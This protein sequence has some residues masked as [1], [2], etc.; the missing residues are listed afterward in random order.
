M[1][2]WIP[3][4]AGLA[5]AGSFSHAALDTVL[6]RVLRDGRVDYGA[7]ARD[8]AD[9]DRYLAAVAAARPDDW[10]REEQIAF[11]V[12]AYNARVLDGVIRRPGLKSVLD[13][14][15]VLGVPTLGFF[16]EERITGGARRTLDDIEHRILR[17]RFPEPRL[18]FVLNCASVSCPLLP[19]RALAAAT[20]EADLE[21]ATRRF[22]AD[23][24]RNRIDPGGRL[25][26]SPIF[27]WYEGDFRQA[28]GSVVAFVAR[29][30]PGGAAIPPDTRID[31]LDYDW[32]LNGSW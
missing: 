11:W 14:R 4:A 15:R 8:H 24:T 16:R 18:H 10:P 13:V 29:Y 32:S 2:V 1:V 5:R 21:A 12:N 30:L 6:A 26:L 23:S 20:L 9:L 27:K 25:R 19:E 17:A 7:L 28:A 3:A 22:L 31:F